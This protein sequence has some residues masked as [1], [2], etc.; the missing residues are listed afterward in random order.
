MMKLLIMSIGPLE[1]VVLCLLLCVLVYGLTRI[2]RAM[3]GVVKKIIDK[4]RNTPTW[5]GIIISAII[6]LLPL[7]LV[8]CFLGYMGEYKTP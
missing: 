2:L 5:E 1:I 3:G 8:L 6:G 4:S 7:Y